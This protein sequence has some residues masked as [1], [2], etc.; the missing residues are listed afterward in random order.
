MRGQSE[1]ICNSQAGDPHS[2]CCCGCVDRLA[3]DQQVA[4]AVRANVAQRH[5]LQAIFLFVLLK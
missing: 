1:R 5:G 4:T 3:I 2:Y